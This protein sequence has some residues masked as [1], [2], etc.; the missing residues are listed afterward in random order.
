MSTLTQLTSTW[1]GRPNTR[2]PE[3]T[4]AYKNA[5]QM[6]VIK[7][8]GEEEEKNADTKYVDTDP[9][10]P[11][12]SQVIDWRGDTDDAVM[13]ANNAYQQTMYETSEHEEDAD[14][15]YPE[16]G[17]PTTQKRLCHKDVQDVPDVKVM[18]N[19][20]DVP[21]VPDVLNVQDM[22]DVPDVP[23]TTAHN[24]SN[25][26]GHQTNLWQTSPPTTRSS[27]PPPSPPTTTS[28]PPPPPRRGGARGGITKC[29]PCA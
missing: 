5:C 17:E 1:S 6:D 28:S 27:L 25:D 3:M 12:K 7:T 2:S 21:S 26:K 4:E 14:K 18:S 20:Q 10:K 24:T 13:L 22:P 19:M 9:D 8:P 11:Q 16:K 23:R 29:A 15:P